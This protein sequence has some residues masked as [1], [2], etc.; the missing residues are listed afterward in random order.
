MTQQRP[1]AGSPASRAKAGRS[2]NRALIGGLA[3]LLLTCAAAAALPGCN[4]STSPTQPDAP[5]LSIHLYP[6]YGLDPSIICSRTR[7]KVI[8]FVPKGQ[9]DGIFPGWQAAAREAFSQIKVFYER[10]FQGR[11]RIETDILGTI[12]YGKKANY[13]Y[14]GDTTHEIEKAV[15]HPSGDYYD[16]AFATEHPGE[17]TVHM[18]Y[19]VNGTGE[20]YIDIP[21]AAYPTLKTAYNPWFWLEE[22]DDFGTVNSAHELGHLL[23]MPHP[24]DMDPPYPNAEG[25]IMGYTTSGLT[26]MQ[27]YVLDEMKRRMGLP[28]PEG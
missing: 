24:W 23:G 12:V 10:E 26:I 6:A 28:V 17:Y 19:Y 15:F 3:L 4:S 18:I 2:I 27:C 21:S 14:V 8:Y 20:N 9:E 1:N 16:P 11:L 25:D 13:P 22:L 5:T 7:V